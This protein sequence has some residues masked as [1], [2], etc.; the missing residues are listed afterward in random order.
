M[1]KYL[2]PSR[3]LP[4]QPSEQEAAAAGVYAGAIATACHS[5][6]QHLRRAAWLSLPI[7][8]LGLLPSIFLLQVYN[9]VI[10]RGGTATL[11]AMVAGVLCF[12]GIE[13]WLRR[14]RA[15]ALR[16]AGAAIDHDVSQALMHSMLQRPLLALEQRPASQ[17][18]QLF[19][20]VGAMRA[21]ITGGLASAMLDLP[22]ALLALIVIGIIAW[23]VLPVI[24]VAMLILGVLAWWW[25][26][27]V[28]SGRVEEIAQARSLDRNTAEVCNARAT[29]KVLGY[30]TAVRQTWQS[31]YDHWLAE[32]FAKNGE[33]E[34]AREAS[35]ILLTFF[36]I[37]VITVGAIAINA[38]WMSIGSLM[39]V[40]LLASKALAPI[41]Q[42]AGNWRSLARSNEATQRL[43]AVLEEPVEQASQDL[44]LPRPKGRLRLDQASFHYPDGRAT[45]EQVSL[46]IGP[47]GLHAILG[48]NG[49]GKST[50]AKLLAGLY[51]PTEGR[52]F[53]DEYDLAQFPRATLGQWVGCL[54]QQVY[55]FS[56][57]IIDGL[58]M[59]NPEA[60]D[61]QIVTATQ[62]AGAH[63]FVSRLPQGYQSVVGEGGAGLS[64]GELRKLALAQLF[65]RNPSVLILD[66]PS[67]DLDFDSETALLQTLRQIARRHTVIVVTHSLRVASAAQHIYHVRGDGHVEQGGPQ[68]MLPRLFG[69][70]R[71]ATGDSGVS[72]EAGA[73]ADTDADTLPRELAA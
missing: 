19:R 63:A 44:Q 18:L 6:W 42:L 7:S 36:S 23:P 35:H 38:Q 28:R 45:L 71:A 40:N 14:R 70:A 57:P 25:A 2:L 8:L 49:A 68:Q 9:R 59:V 55:W 65:L 3:L 56:G 29:L 39:A 37:A 62:L 5:A 21:S 43:Q 52:V 20:D 30:D 1:I 64:A 11:T 66:E 54:A 10:A 24:L 53:I 17:W 4:Q 58:R 51:R 16:E 60:T 69:T 15:R 12:L 32:S 22:M 72:A 73:D 41:A 26:D 46:D 50:L 61:Q 13:W 47:G 27:E 33:L 31:G 48:R 34:N 67:N